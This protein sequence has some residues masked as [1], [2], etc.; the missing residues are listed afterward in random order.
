MT[1]LDKIYKAIVIVSIML[2]VLWYPVT[3][4]LADNFSGSFGGNG[5]FRGSAR[6]GEY[7]WY[8]TYA[9]IGLPLLLLLSYF[10]F[11]LHG[12]FRK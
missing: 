10:L 7:F 12:K 9:I 5:V 4:Y 6:A 1:K 2:G 8:Y 11:R 3:W